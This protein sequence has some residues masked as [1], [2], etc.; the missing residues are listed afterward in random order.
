MAP[1]DVSDLI[2]MDTSF[3]IIRVEEKTEEKT[4]SLDSVYND[5]GNTLRDKLLQEQTEKFLK[6][7]RE[8]AIVEVRL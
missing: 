4:M 1:G 5:I 7:L 3:R 8:Q 2:R 6:Q